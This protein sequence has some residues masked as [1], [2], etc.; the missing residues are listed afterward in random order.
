MKKTLFIAI[1]FVFTLTS[2]IMAQTTADDVLAS[3]ERFEKLAKFN[4]PKEVGSPNIDK[5]TVS[6]TSVAIESQAITPLLQNLYYRSI[7]QTS[8]GVTDVTIKKPTVAECVELSTRIATQ[9]L[10]VKAST[11]AISGASTDLKSLSPLK[12][13][14]A[15]K[16][17]NYSKDVLAIVGVE[18]LYQVKAI[19]AMI[20]TA[21]SAKSL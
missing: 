7:G 10:A 20:E 15:A 14:K 3:K 5:L 8:E 9:A 17:F 13:I 19:A 16:S 1:A 11:E 18:S 4:A 21:K 6:S 2:N 12:A